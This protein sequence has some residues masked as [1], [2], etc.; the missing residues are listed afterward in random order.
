MN[1]R[2]MEANIDSPKQGSG[3]EQL[4]FPVRRVPLDAPW[5]WLSRGWRDLCTVPSVSVAYG[6]FF[7]IA[8]WIILF[9][10]SFL[11]ATSLIP[12]LAAGF[13]L[14]GPLLAA[15]LYETSR[16]L[17]KGE[18]ITVREVFDG[19][20]PAIGRLGFF[21]V[22]LFFAFFAWVEL[23]FLLLTL[24]LGGATVPAP[25][26]FVHTLLSTNAGVGLLTGTL[27]GAMLAA[28]VFSSVAVPLL[29]VKDVDAVTAM[30][31][32]VRA[33]RLNTG[34][35][36]LWATLIAGYVVLG[37]WTLFLGLVIIFPLLGHA[38]WHAFRALVEVDGI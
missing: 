19:C 16:R 11:E 32:S 10:L 34:T 35:M 37:T 33:V 3:V 6:A 26:E 23:A 30:V 18:P 17:E 1:S 28:M 7:S 25:S 21:G 5:D 8:A 22:V 29:L 20:A 12:V 4:G 31:T 13:M 27:T 36:L 38:T 24:F 14:V 2:L 9:V 15:G